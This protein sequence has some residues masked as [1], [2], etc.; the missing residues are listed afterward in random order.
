MPTLISGFAMLSLFA[1]ISCGTTLA[2][3]SFAELAQRATAIARVRCLG[4]ESKWLGNEIWT[5]THFQVL[6]QDKGSLN[7]ALTIRML[8]GSVGNFHSRVDGV[9]VFHAGEEVYLFLWARDG[10]PFRVLGWSQG[11]FRISRNPRTGAENLTQDSAET[12]V[13]QQP[14]RQFV[15]DGIRGLSVTDFRQ[16]L[17]KILAATAP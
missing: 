14:S 12:P 9:P 7:P 5:E 17:Q 2:R 16:R 13:Y 6:E 15:R 1:S 4:T 11:T 10:E 8:G 3:L